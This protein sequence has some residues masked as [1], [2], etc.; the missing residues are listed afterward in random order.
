MIIQKRMIG[1][2]IFLVLSIISFPTR[3]SAQ[4]FY[5]TAPRFG[6]NSIFGSTKSMG[7]GGIQMGVG[8]EGAALAVNPAAPGLLRKSEIQFS[9]VPY[10]N[11]TSN[12]FRDGT[13]S[14]DKSGMPVGSFS[15]SLTS[16]KTEDEENPIR[17]GVFTVSYNRIS[18]FH[19][20]TVWEGETPL[21]Q[22]N[23]SQ[24]STNS[25]IDLYLAGANK[26][27]T[28]PSQTILKDGNSDPIV[29]SDNFKNDLVMG[30]NAYLLDTSG[31]SFV[32]A[33]PRSDLLKAGY[34]DQTLNHGMWNFGYSVNIKEKTFLGVSIGYVRGNYSSE[35]Q[36]GETIKN[37]Y[38]NPGNSD[39]TYLQGFK[40]VNFQR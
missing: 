5:D 11:S 9:L 38:V 16:L 34:Y 25:I 8:G 35:V 14:A 37:V 30:Y 3:T 1:N 20:K 10:L 7:M 19:R 23:A 29:F 22:N 33:F 27:G 31:G 32:S 4:G 39:F 18:V 13:V 6:Q 21:Y 2:Y 17:A 24:P 26:P 40:G 12:T 15:L 28:F 36:Y